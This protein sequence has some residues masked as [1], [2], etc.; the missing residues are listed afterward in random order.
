MNGHI[1]RHV[2]VCFFPSQSVLLPTSRSERSRNTSSL[3]AQMCAKPHCVATKKGKKDTLVPSF[4]RHFFH[5][6]FLHYLFISSTE[7]TCSLSDLELVSTV[8]MFLNYSITLHAHFKTLGASRLSPWISGT[9]NQ[10]CCCCCCSLRQLSTCQMNAAESKIRKAALFKT[11]IGRCVFNW[12]ECFGLSVCTW[13][14]C[15][16]FLLH[17]DSH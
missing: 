17:G 15:Q 11:A 6:R 12:H 3:C 2:T 5:Q 1:K 16:L 13:K 9:I 8:I 4:V 10:S 14:C 7:R